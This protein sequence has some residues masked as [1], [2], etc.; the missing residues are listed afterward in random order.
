MRTAGNSD[1]RWGIR[2]QQGRDDGLQEQTDTPPPC[3]WQNG[4][5]QV[6]L[7]RDEK[8]SPA[9][10]E[11]PLDSCP[12]KLPGRANTG[13]MLLGEPRVWALC[14]D[15]DHLERDIQ[16]HRQRQRRAENLGAPVPRLPSMLMRLCILISRERWRMR[17]TPATL[18]FWFTRF[19]DRDALAESNRDLVKYPLS[20][21]RS[22]IE[23]MPR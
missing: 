15:V 13:Q 22:V 10:G 1:G 23:G 3:Q 2:C 5:R 18:S 8:R 4:I 11:C 21:H 6:P 17:G 20:T 9:S 14:S 12:A 19:R 16:C 7:H